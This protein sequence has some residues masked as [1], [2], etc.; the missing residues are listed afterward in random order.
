MN[1]KQRRVA[2]RATER[3]VDAFVK[4][5]PG[6][7]IAA[8]DVAAGIAR[9]VDSVRLTQDALRVS[10]TTFAAAAEAQL[11]GLRRWTGSMTIAIN[12][13]PSSDVLPDETVATLLDLARAGHEADFRWLAASAGV[14]AEEMD[15]LWNGTVARTR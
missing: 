10:A 4:W 12:L 7:Q 11:E 15:R 9:L 2:R 3:Q 1:A 5:A 14:K 13:E 6:F 8:D